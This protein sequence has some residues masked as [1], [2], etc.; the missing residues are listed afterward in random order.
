MK[1]LGA[2]TRVKYIACTI[3]Y[4]AMSAGLTGMRP[5]KNKIISMTAMNKRLMVLLIMKESCQI[6]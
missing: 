4:D 6:Q 1:K 3:I 5:G 2:A